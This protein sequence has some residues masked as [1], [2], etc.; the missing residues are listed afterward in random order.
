M[1]D[2]QRPR[3]RIHFTPRSGWINDPL[4]VTWHNG[5]Y[6]LF[7]Q[8]VPD[9]TTWKPDCRWGHATSPDLVTWT[10]RPIALEPGEGDDGIWSG[11]LVVDDHGHATIFYT[12]VTVP[13]FGVGAVRTATPVDDDWI[14]W[15]KGDV[16]VEAPPL[17]LVAFRDPFVMRDG[18]QWRMLVGTALEGGDAGASS[19]SS[20]DLR[21][22]VFEGL[23]ASRNT[24]ETQPVWTGALW[25]CPQIFTIDGRHV[26][27]T[28][29]WQDD[30]LHYVIYAIGE[31]ANGKFRAQHW[32][33]LTYGDSYY[34]PSFFRDRDGLPCLIYWMRG[35]LDEDAARASA[36]SVPHTLRL[37]GATLVATPHP[38]VCSVSAAEA[39]TLDESQKLRM[40]LEVGDE[41]AISNVA[42]TVVLGRR[43]NGVTCSW[44]DAVTTLP[45]STGPVEVL[46]DGETVEVFG[47]GGVLGIGS[48]S[49]F[50]RILT[51]A[52]DD[53]ARIRRF[54][55]LSASD[56]E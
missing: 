51:R 39:D 13:D 40:A 6:H 9:S 32:G 37:E 17:D 7:F 1:T 36:L 47:H 3:P 55:L 8:Y 19:F 42:G 26:M 14:V 56:G 21:T 30:E 44:Q 45:T 46:V 29:V 2:A 10:E 5:Q 31:F 53:D 25:E 4:G 20:D 28:S 54:G 52:L 23:A 12:S 33:R 11:S 38:A 22:W 16:V 34:A 27:V 41:L 15:K 49:A 18:E 24:Q 50:T 48:S 43:S 35:V